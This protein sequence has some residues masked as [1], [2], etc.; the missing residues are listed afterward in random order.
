MNLG[1]AKLKLYLRQYPIE[2]E[3]NDIVMCYQI[4]SKLVNKFQ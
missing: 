3:G 2:K 4:I 1:Q